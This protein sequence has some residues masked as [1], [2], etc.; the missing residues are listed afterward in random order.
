MN[1]V[2]AGVPPSAVARERSRSHDGA[3]SWRM[4]EHD[5]LFS[6]AFG[7]E[8]GTAYRMTRAIRDAFRGK[9]ILEGLS[10]T[11]DLEEFAGAGRCEARR[12]ARPHPAVQAEWSRRCGISEATQTALFDVSWRGHD[13]VVAQAT[14]PEGYSRREQRWIVADSM[15]I[16]RELAAEVCAFCNEPRE[17]VLAFRGGCWSKSR[18]LWL[19]IQSASLDEL[20]LAG[21]LA[22]EIRDD[23]TSF[24]AAR[25]EYERYGVP[26]KRGVL[27]VGPPG[28]GK[29]LCLRATIKLLGVTCLYV[30]SLQSRYDTDD[31]NIARVFD[32][33]REV[34][35][36][37]LVFEDLDALITPKNRSSF[38]NQLDGFA[39]ASGMLTLAT[40][41]HPER[42]DPA[43]LERPSRFDRK[44]HFGLPSAAERARYVDAWRALVDA[45]MRIADREAA[46]LVEGPAGVSFA[47]L[48]ELFLSAM[49][50]WMK[51][52]S[53]GAMH[54]ILRSQLA[55]LRDQMR[56]EP[57]PTPEP[58]PPKDP[59]DDDD[60]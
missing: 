40:T 24:L 59:G 56:T 42:L 31:A 52:R 55:T 23:F 35:P 7:P 25:A 58:H 28:N 2:Q 60:E 34:T 5:D 6:G 30:Q 41:N 47:Y 26:W 17:A 44:Y 21:D 49:I 54:G 10:H 45:A 33:A 29:T 36:C 15:A 51:E 50:R 4:S 14:W 19:A 22:N 57:S 46:T 27:F 18:E 13:L 11:F 32:R 8:A 20:V 16:A 38:L 9:A 1:A 37:C 39:N 3:L 53:E 48:K 12:R 43:I